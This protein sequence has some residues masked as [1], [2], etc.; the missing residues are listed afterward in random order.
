MSKL[1][2]HDSNLNI[3]DLNIFQ[4]IK[5]ILPYDLPKHS[6]STVPEPMEAANQTKTASLL[7]KEATN[8]NDTYCRAC[9][10]KFTNKLTYV[11]HLKSA[12]HIANEK[13]MKPTLP[14]SSSLSKPI[15]SGKIM[16][17]PQVQEALNKLE[18]AQKSSDPTSSVTLYWNLAHTFYTL[19]YPQY[20]A[21]SLKLIIETLTSTSST[22]FSSAQVTAFLYNSRLA[23]ARLF[24]IYQQLDECRTV[25]LDALEGKWK[26]EKMEL[27]NIAKNLRHLSIIELLQSCDQLANRYLTRERNRTKPAP[28]L[29][30]PNNS[31]TFILNEAANLFAQEGHLFSDTI[32]TEHV[33]IV[34]YATCS[35]TCPYEQMPGF[36][37]NDFYSLMTQI[38]ASLD[39]L[40]H[41]I[42]EVKMLDTSNIWN[43]FYSLL[44]S[45]EIDDLV[46]AKSIK[47][48][49][50]Q[51]ETYS[52]YPDVKLLC[53]LYEYKITLDSS[54]NLA[55][56]L[57]HITLIL[58]LTNEP[59]LIRQQTKQVQEDV[60][61]RIRNLI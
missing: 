57:D 39:G 28:A 7:Q 26:I 35:L 44:L 5:K 37:K 19:K 50:L 32:L 34:L 6:V 8:D 38:Y 61:N 53:D 25:Y 55:Y 27:L 22:T 47:A 13:K 24:C 15:S 11:N 45:I 21:K 36:I 9:K 54:S 29:T 2:L 52:L 16:V 48:S 10:K 40:T 41:R 46:R 1:P 30:D 20:T 31:I 3:Q 51:Q 18:A 17:N 49:L 43:I 33:S 4:P 42:I 60:L 12:K 14:S 59:L 56:D 23:L 58:E